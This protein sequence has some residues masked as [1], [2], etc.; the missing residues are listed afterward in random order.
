MIE[1]PIEE[2]LK[3]MTLEEKIGQLTLVGLDG[4]EVNEQTRSL[5]EDYYVGGFIVLGGNVESTEQLIN[6]TNELKRINTN[7]TIPLFLAIDEE[8][9]N[10]SRM[11]DE[12]VD[13]PTN[14]LIGNVNDPSLSYEIGQ[15]LAHQIKSFGFNINFAP[16]M[17]VDS[18]P[19]N[20]V[21]GDRSF[22]SNVEIVSKLGIETMKGMQAEGVISVVKHFPGHGDTFVDSHL[23]LPRVNKDLNNLMEFEFV[24]F[25]ETINNGADA[26]MVAH[27]LYEKIDPEYPASLSN[28][29]ISG[30]LREQLGF[31]GLIFTDDLTM[32]AILD[33]YDITEAAILSIKAGNDIVLVAHE[34]QMEVLKALKKAV[35]TGEISEERVN[36]SVYRILKFKLD[37]DLHDK[38]ID[39]VDV[40]QINSRLKEII[41]SIPTK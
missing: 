34:N 35:E 13:L 25:I 18:N 21:I 1:D 40:N 6:L 30:I 3:K 9:G 39:F 29:I 31:D 15:T 38:E 28:E 33:N 11:P 36:E 32:A 20:P 41:D 12:F 8:G 24:P 5:I 7:N 23:G 26:M 16:V 17:D 22:S 10:I 2:K 27:I 4:Y 37:Y 14:Q 19:D